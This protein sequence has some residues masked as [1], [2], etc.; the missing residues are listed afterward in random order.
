VAGESFAVTYCPL[1][2]SAIVYDREFGT[3]PLTLG[4]SGN[5]TKATRSSTITDRK[6]LVSDK[7]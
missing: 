3:K 7:R 6:S 5:C 1:T 4:V 2:A